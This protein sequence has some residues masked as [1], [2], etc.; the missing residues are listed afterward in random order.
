MSLPDGRGVEVIH[1]FEAR[2]PSQPIIV[3]SGSLTLDD[4]VKAI[5]G[6]GDRMCLPKPFGMDAFHAA[7]SNAIG[8]QGR[9]NLLPDAYR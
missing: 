3:M 9:L 2:F 7:V 1:R 6:H 4:E 8:R 5:A